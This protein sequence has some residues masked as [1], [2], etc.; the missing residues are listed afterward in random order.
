[1]PKAKEV[2]KSAADDILHDKN[3]ASL[4]ICIKSLANNNI[5][6]REAGKVGDAIVP[7][8]EA[9]IRGKNLDLGALATNADTLDQCLK[10]FANHDL[11]KYEGPSSLID[12]GK[13]ALHNAAHAVADEL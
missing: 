12:A 1:M 7:L 13:E 3:Q 11:V 9:D 4:D 6:L 10:K 8:S 5:Q 2:L